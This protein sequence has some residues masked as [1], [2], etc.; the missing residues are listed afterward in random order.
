ML[1]LSSVAMNVFL[2]YWTLVTLIP[3]VLSFIYIRRYY[4]RTS[5]EVKRI[6]AVNRSPILVHVNNTIS[7]VSVIRATNSRD[8]LVH[9]YN[10]HTDYHTRAV[11]AFVSLNRWFAI[12]LGEFKR[13]F[14]NLET[15]SFV[16]YPHKMSIFL[17]ELSLGT[18]LFIKMKVKFL[19]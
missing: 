9:E 18:Q 1:V 16:T 19:K 14:F 6:E 7:G 10:A 12:R 2:N 11:S 8:T 17:D 4:L 3:L 13:D 5:L 15:S